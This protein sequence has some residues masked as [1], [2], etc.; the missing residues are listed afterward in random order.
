MHS[1]IAHAGVVALVSCVPGAGA[2]FLVLAAI[3]VGGL[4]VATTL[5]GVGSYRLGR[6]WGAS[7]PHPPPAWWRAAPVVLVVA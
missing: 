6:D 5:S 2:S 4:V 7:A 1:Q 3:I